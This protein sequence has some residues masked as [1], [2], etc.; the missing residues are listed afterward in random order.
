MKKLL[1]NGLIFFL[2]AQ[3]LPGIMVSGLWG[4]IWSA[5]IYSVLMLLVGSVLKFITFPINFVTFGLMEFIINAIILYLTSGLS[6]ELYVKSFGSA[7]IA[8]VVLAILQ[9]LLLPQKAN[10][11]N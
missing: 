3:L 9:G 7:I 8:A 2:L 10:K 6:G 5:F 11:V 4:A 1:I